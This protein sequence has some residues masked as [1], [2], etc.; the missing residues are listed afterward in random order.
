MA[1]RAEESRKKSRE[2]Q[3]DK[4][5]LQEPLKVKDAVYY[6][7]GKSHKLDT[8]WEPHYHIIKQRGPVS[9]TIRHC[10][11]RKTKEVH[12]RHLRKANMEWPSVKAPQNVR[13][14]TLVVPDT[15]DYSDNDY[16]RD[17]V[18]APTSSTDSSENDEIDE[19]DEENDKDADH[20]NNDEPQS[21]SEDD[22]DTP[23]EHPVS[24]TEVAEPP[25]AAAL[26]QPEE[27]DPVVPEGPRQKRKYNKRVFPSLRK[28]PRKLRYR[29]VPVVPTETETPPAPHASDDAGE[30]SPKEGE[31]D[32][33]FTQQAV[34]NLLQCITDI[35]R[36]K[37]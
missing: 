19:H 28:S 30:E 29:S 10:I 14:S 3:K 31:D 7:K 22:S 11:T 1:K 32:E 20:E 9:F 33:V 6:L 24:P 8:K 34:V 15:S 25:G 21:R 18:D 35:V 17:H 13:K 4:K 37:K 12:A 27:V 23:T 16:V 2:Q 5:K 26:D 36:P